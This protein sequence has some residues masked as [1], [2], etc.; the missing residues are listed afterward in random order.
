MAIHAIHLHDLDVAGLEPGTSEIVVEGEEARHAQRVKRVREG[1]AVFILDGRGTRLRGE[2]ARTGRSLAVRVLERD[3]LAPLQPAIRVCSPP[4]KGPRLGA[5]VDALSQV[6][7]AAWSP[8]ETSR[9]GKGLTESRRRR[10]D[11]VA[12]ESAKQCGRPWLLE[13]GEAATWA[14]AMERLKS[15]DAGSVVIADT[16]GA[17]YRATGEDDI[18]ILIGPEG[19]FTEA[20]QQEAA[21]AG[22]KRCAFGPHTM[23]ME[24][25]A[26]V[27]A[28]IV[29]DAERRRARSEGHEGR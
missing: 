4:P 8:L 12:V 2:V 15:R 10:L 21:E 28:A 25:A 1:E 22:A 26:P 5:L 13:I 27:A 6:G 29:L 16:S 9:A 18:D 24:L 20:E 11:R 7:A 3:S 23:R 14:Q 19:G 17:A